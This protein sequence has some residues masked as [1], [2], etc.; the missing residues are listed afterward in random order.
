MGPIGGQLLVNSAINTS[1]VGDIHELI[2][3]D[4]ENKSKKFDESQRKS[5]A[6][7]QWE[8]LRKGCNKSEQMSWP[9]RQLHK[10]RG[11]Q[12]KYGNTNEELRC[13]RR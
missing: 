8:K 11:D 10:R 3:D 5:R 12:M 9:Q 2:R 4:K 6:K 7:S 13:V 1:N